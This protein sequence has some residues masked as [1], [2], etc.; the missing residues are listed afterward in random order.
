LC[1]FACRALCVALAFVTAVVGVLVAAAGAALVVDFV[2]PP[3]PQPAV[4][5]ATA[6]TVQS[7]PRF[8]W[9][10]SLCLSK[11]S[12]PDYK[13]ISDYKGSQPLQTAKGAM[14]SYR[15][16]AALH[17]C[18]FRGTIAGEESMAEAHRAMR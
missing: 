7:R 18:A 1:C 16:T 15:L 11:A 4:T 13:P 12:V 14:G 17:G 6:A 5:T 10:D 3:L 8:I 9:P 2:D